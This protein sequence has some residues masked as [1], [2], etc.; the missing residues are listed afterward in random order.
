MKTFKV[1][2]VLQ[3]MKRYLFEL[4]TN[5][6]GIR[7]VD[8]RIIFEVENAERLSRKGV[9]EVVKDTE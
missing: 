6:I 1:N 3:D 9:Q 2:D 4:E 7:K 8:N 5:V